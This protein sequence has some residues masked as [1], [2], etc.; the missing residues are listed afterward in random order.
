MLIQIYG[1]CY[2]HMICHINTTELLRFDLSFLST[3]LA[4]TKEKKPYLIHLLPRGLDP[5][6]GLDQLFQTR[7]SSKDFQIDY[8]TSH[9]L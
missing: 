5:P 1:L 4:E 8:V 2:V 3:L 6:A 7:R 9:L